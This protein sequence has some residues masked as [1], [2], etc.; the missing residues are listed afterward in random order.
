MVEKLRRVVFKGV[1]QIPELSRVAGVVVA[2]SI[3]RWMNEDL[4]LDWTE[5]A[6]GGLTF[7]RR[8]LVWDAYK[9]YNNI[10]FV[11]MLH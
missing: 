6:W 3:N 9:Y 11:L 7:S 5:R 2:Y 10:R 8:V 1:R 4:T